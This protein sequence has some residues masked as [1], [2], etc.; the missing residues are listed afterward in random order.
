MLLFLMENKF[1]LSFRG[2]YLFN[3]CYDTYAFTKSLVIRHNSRYSLL[4]E[5]IGDSTYK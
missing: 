1:H 2:K 4:N 3:L 5:P